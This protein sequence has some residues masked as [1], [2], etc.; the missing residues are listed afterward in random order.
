MRRQREKLDRY[1]QYWS[2]TAKLTR[3]IQGGLC[4]YPGC[5]RKIWQVHHAVYQ[6]YDEFKNLVPIRG[7]EKPGIHAF[8]VCKC[9]HSKFN[10]LGAHHP[11][12]WEKGVVEPDLLDAKQKPEYYQKLL[13]G[14]KEKR[15]IAEKQR[16]IAGN[17]HDVHILSA[18]N[19][20]TNS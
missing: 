4:A 16:A 2:W 11:L 8:G 10:P 18:N 17:W 9:H 5:D 13:A 20:R 19:T 6:E 14:F 15:E 7:R 1:A 3:S 12:N